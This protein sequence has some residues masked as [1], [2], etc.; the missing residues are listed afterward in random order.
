MP[1]VYLAYSNHGQTLNVT[2]DLGYPWKRSEKSYKFQA[3]DFIEWPGDMQLKVAVELLAWPIAGVEATPDFPSFPQFGVEGDGV[4][5]QLSDK[6][7]RF[8]IPLISKDGSANLQIPWITTRNDK[9][10]INTKSEHSWSSSPCR[11][12]ISLLIVFQPPPGKS[13]AVVKDWFRRFCPG[14]L[15]SLGKRS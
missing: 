14:G 15:P 13:P 12:S 6:S 9:L 11:C 1:K 4:S 7:L 3:Q 2:C 8:S 10:A 5:Y